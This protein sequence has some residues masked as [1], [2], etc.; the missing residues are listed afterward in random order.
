M[1]P[2]APRSR[3]AWLVVTVAAT[4][5]WFIG[6]YIPALSNI[7][8]GLNVL[9]PAGQP[10]RITFPFAYPAVGVNG[11]T[12]ASLLGLLLILGAITRWLTYLQRHTPPPS[13]SPPAPAVQTPTPAVQATGPTRPST[14]VTASE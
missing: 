2:A 11:H 12:A 3:R 4:I 10:H 1:E 8:V 5:L 6:A 14:P 9:A 13:E 7:W